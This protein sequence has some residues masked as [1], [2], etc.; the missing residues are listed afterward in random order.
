MLVLTS[1]QSIPELGA[2][3]GKPK[4]GGDA[5]GGE[6]GSDGPRGA[7]LQRAESLDALDQVA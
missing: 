5:L 6:G 2:N 7:V 4:I 1:R 3:T